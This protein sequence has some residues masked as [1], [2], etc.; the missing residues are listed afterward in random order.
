[1]ETFALSPLLQIYLYAAILSSQN[2]VECCLA[3]TVL[4]LPV[5]Q[6]ITS[7]VFDERSETPAVLSFAAILLDRMGLM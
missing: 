1:M 5:L 4:E 2:R 7:L 6:Y 3:L